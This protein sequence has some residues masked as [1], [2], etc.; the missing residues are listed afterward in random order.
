MKV[1]FVSSTCS[2]KQYEEICKKRK[3]PVLDSSQKFFDMFLKGLG[4]QENVKIDCICVPPVS[5]G[6]FPG[7]YIDE[8]RETV[9]NIT[10]YSVA[11][12][13]YPVL[14]SLTAQIAVKKQLRRLL[15]NCME[16]T[17]LVADPLLLEAAVPVVK[18]G[19]KYG[20]KSIGFLTDLPDFADECDEHSGVKAG[21]YTLYNKKCKRNLQKFSHYVFLTE[22]MNVSVNQN[23]KPWMLMECLVDVSSVK[24]SCCTSNVEI[25]S[26]LYAGKLH[27]EFGLDILAGVTALVKEK[28]MFNIYGDGNYREELEMRAAKQKNICVH[29]IVSVNEIIKEEM[30]S[31]LLVNPRTSQGEFTKYSFP[32]KTAEYMLTGVPVVMFKLPGIPNE[33][34]EYLYYVEKESAESFAVKIDEVLS[35]PQGVLEEKGKRAREFVIREKNN[36]KQAQ[37]FI[38]FCANNEGR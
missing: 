7:F 22:A 19:Q 32:S 24:E 37:R 1:I 20:V 34:D 38:K 26:I 11:L 14:K 31:T 27:K 36:V 23:G 33:Y 30:K 21:L 13:N 25:P 16:E 15:A 29:G 5:H 8:C 10:Y 35:L 18:A 12:V 3:Y 9:G 28:C 2:P 4:E 17:I 6:T